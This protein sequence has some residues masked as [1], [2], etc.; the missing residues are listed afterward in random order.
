[1]KAVMC[2]ESGH[3][4]TLIQ[5]SIQTGNSNGDR[6]GRRVANGDRVGRE[7]PGCPDS[8]Q[9]LLAG[10]PSFDFI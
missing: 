1:M 8:G 6:V 10:N 3:S 7:S 4:E 5:K 9:G 2:P